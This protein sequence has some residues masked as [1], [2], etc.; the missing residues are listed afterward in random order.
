MVPEERDRL[1]ERTVFAQDLESSYIP[2]VPVPQPLGSQWPLSS[3]ADLVKLRNL[4]IVVVSGGSHHDLTMLA[5]PPYAAA[6][7]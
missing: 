7:N 2:T 3:S 1:E 6:G 4:Y 5:L